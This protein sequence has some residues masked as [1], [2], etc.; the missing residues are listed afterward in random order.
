[1]QSSEVVHGKHIPLEDEIQQVSKLA[2][3]DLA[4]FS[5]SWHQDL[6]GTIVLGI[7]EPEK[8]EALGL[9]LSWRS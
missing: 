1:M 5:S 4:E 9:N 3:Q 7:S 2:Y 8:L 6:Q